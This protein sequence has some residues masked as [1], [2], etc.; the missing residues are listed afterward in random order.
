M[1]AISIK[2]KDALVEKP[3]SDHYSYI[4]EFPNEFKKKWYKQLDTRFVI[5]LLLTFV[6][7][8]GTLLLLLSW[9]K[10]RETDLNIY[11]IH[12]K[13]ANLLLKQFDSNNID[14]F[15]KHKDTYL[16]GVT[17]NIEPPA[18]IAENQN[19]TAND[20]P[21]EKKT[22]G[23]PGRTVNRQGL[24]Q[25]TSG[26]QPGEQ[27]ALADDLSTQVAKQGL[28]NYFTSDEGTFNNEEIREIF[29]ITDR[30]SSNLERSL[31]NVKL[32]SYNKI[33][34]KVADFAGSGTVGKRKGS[35][36]TV[37]TEDLLASFTPINQATISAV[38]KN[39]ELE[40]VS[41]SVLAGGGKKTSARKAENVAQV[42]HSHNRAVQDC[43]RQA[44]KKEPDLRGKVVVR[45]MIAPGGGVESVQILQST[46]QYEPML[47]C[48][49]NR[50]QRWNDFGDSDPSLG[51]IG[52]RQT[53]VF[54]Y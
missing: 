40:N 30:Y 33:E 41:L 28:L 44:L 46:I 3:F 17:E 4:R 24:S 47:Q 13:Y 38:A 34:G 7:E 8:V 39:T 26:S 36:R 42:I 32:A 31:S 12:E 1:R 51:S 22:S 21:I 50:I 6:F 43:Y 14:Y 15:E 27:G 53:Y 5:I 16:F 52:Y 11:T 45:I 49:M 2:E 23:K 37:S 35:K 20:A 10:N 29:S 48:M 54:G 9:V 18:S 25:G 19:F